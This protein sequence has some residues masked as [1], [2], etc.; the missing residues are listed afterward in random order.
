MG[1]IAQKEYGMTEADL[2]GKKFNAFRNYVFAQ[3]SIMKLYQI[4]NA[5]GEEALAKVTKEM[6]TT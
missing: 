3:A 1:K 2:K 4:L 6:V 5:Q